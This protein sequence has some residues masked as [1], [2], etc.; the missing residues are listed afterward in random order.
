MFFVMVTGMAPDLNSMSGGNTKSLY[1]K[2]FEAEVA[3]RRFAE[4]VVAQIP[5]DK[6]KRGLKL[7]L[8]DGDKEKVIDVV[9]FP[10]PET[11]WKS[12]QNVPAST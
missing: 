4:E 1:V 7:F 9:E 10:G 12:K 8:I 6:R 3:A 11:P 2:D 5:D